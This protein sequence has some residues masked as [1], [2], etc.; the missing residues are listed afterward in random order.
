MSMAIACSFLLP[1]VQAR[2]QYQN[3]YHRDRDHDRD[4]R[5]RDRY[6]DRGYRDY[7]TWNNNESVRW[8]RYWEMRRRREIAWER[9]NERQRRAYWRWRHEYPIY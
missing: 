6:Y 1:V 7:H 5:D 2:A 3:Q 8:H 9:A 4:D